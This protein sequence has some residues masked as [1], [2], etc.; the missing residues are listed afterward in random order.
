PP[1]SHRPHS[2]SQTVRKCPTL[3][4]SLRS[5]T[6]ERTTAHHPLAPIAKRT[7]PFMFHVFTF[8]SPAPLS[9]CKT[10]P[11]IRV[12]ASKLKI[13]RRPAQNKPTNATPTK[14]TVHAPRYTAP[15]PAARD[16]E[17]SSPPAGAAGCRWR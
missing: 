6:P 3:Q 5:D 11:P 12:R 16:I 4:N 1:P 14:G 15:P 8:H 17:C 7:H 9:R 10:N 2:T 13:L